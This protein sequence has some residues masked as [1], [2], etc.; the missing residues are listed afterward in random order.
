MRPGDVLVVNESRVLPVRLL[1]AKPT[2]ARAEVLLLRPLGEAETPGGT[3]G[4]GRL[5][6]GG[7]A[8][9]DGPAGGPDV[10]GAGGGRGG[11]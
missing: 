3:D 9:D 11:R 6:G 1:G 4:G 10:G 8:R 5:A 7:P 2:G